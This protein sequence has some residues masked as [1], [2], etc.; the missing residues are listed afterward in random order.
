[1]KIGVVCAICVINV[2][3]GSDTSK[4]P[5]SHG[6]GKGHYK[7]WI[8]R[9]ILKPSSPLHLLKI[10]RFGSLALMECPPSPQLWII[11]GVFIP[12]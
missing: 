11:L 2:V 7:V 10:R 12:W 9:T 4:H 5:L 3:E 8:H 6:E 1:M